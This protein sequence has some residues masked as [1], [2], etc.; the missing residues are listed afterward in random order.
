M[1]YIYVT[2]YDEGI[3]FRRITNNKEI[4][5]FKLQIKMLMEI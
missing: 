5:I 2:S 1:K 3:A 4:S